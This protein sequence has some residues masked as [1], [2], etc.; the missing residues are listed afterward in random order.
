MGQLEGRSFF[1]GVP[2]IPI[3]LKRVKILDDGIDGS[4]GMA[5]GMIQG[6]R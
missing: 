2:E 3:K 1:F 4:M 5:R 6:R